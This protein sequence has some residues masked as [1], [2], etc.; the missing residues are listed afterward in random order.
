MADF[1]ALDFETANERRDSA[2]SIG[3]SVVRG[4]EVTTAEF[5]I[6]PPEM[7]FARGNI[8][9]HG[10]TPMMVANAPTFA[11]LYPRIAPL[12]AR[13]PLW[14][15]YAPFDQSVLNAL[16]TTYG[17]SLPMGLN[18]TCKLAKRLLPRLPA[19]K[20]NIVCDHLGI[21]VKHHN[22]ASDA[23]AC[24]RIVLWAREGGL[25]GA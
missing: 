15:H 3:I 17:L 25:L 22:A 7:R 1:V 18:C 21:A 9:V 23:E 5:L 6:R 24:A 8:Q 16:A 19:H 14:A 11:V 10:I 13:G 2:C 20:L 4:N 12:L